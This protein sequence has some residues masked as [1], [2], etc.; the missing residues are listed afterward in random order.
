MSPKVCTALKLEQG[1]N[2]ALPLGKSD[3]FKETVPLPDT[4]VS[5]KQQTPTV[6]TKLNKAHEAGKQSCSGGYVLI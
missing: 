2:E 6:L 5:I 3:P 1:L 4:H